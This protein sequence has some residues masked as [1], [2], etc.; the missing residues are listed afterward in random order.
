M[1]KIKVILSAILYSYMSSSIYAQQHD[2]DSFNTGFLAC[3]DGAGIN[4]IIRKEGG[5]KL[6]MM[7]DF[8]SKEWTIGINGALKNEHA[9]QYIVPYLWYTLFIDFEN[10]RAILRD[11]DGNDSLAYCNLE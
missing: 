9:D 1:T 11:H 7:S 6:R 5:D 2:F 4:F 10:S 8:Y 3:S